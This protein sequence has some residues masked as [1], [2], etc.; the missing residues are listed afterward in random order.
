MPWKTSW[1]KRWRLELVI[2]VS[3]GLLLVGL[4]APFSYDEAFITFRYAANLSRGLGLVYNPGERYLGTTGP[5]WA[6]L[7]GGLHRLVPF[8]SV[9]QWATIL[10][11]LALLVIGIAVYRLMQHWGAG[12]WAAWAAV[13]CMAHPLV[14]MPIGGEVVPVMALV[15]LAWELLLDSDQKVRLDAILL[16]EKH[17]G[18]DTPDRALVGWAW[19]GFLASVA[20]WL[21]PDAFVAFA[22]MATTETIRRRS[23][24][25]KMLLIYGLTLLPWLWFSTYYFGTLFPGTL[26]TKTAQCEAGLWSCFLPGLLDWIRMGLF[27]QA[28]RWVAYLSPSLVGWTNPILVLGSTLYIVILSIGLIKVLAQTPLALAVFLW[29]LL[30]SLGYV[31]LR[32]PFYPWY[33]TPLGIAFGLGLGLAAWGLASYGSWRRW[34]SLFLVTLAVAGYSLWHL[35]HRLDDVPDPR[36]AIQHRLAVWFQSVVPPGRSLM[37]EEIGFLGYELLDYK[38]YDVWGLVTPGLAQTIRSRDLAAGVWRYQ[39][40]YFIA[41]PAD[42]APEGSFR[43]IPLQPWFQRTYRPVTRFDHT[44][45]PYAP[46]IVIYER[47]SQ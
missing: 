6:I 39:P 18:K 34:V 15:L 5:G 30:H 44:G 10:S 21:R 24:P 29:P 37:G 42:G 31:L 4:Y 8:L 47:V 16:S 7:L 2:V 26:A 23:I 33:A 38:V 22:V 45:L 40:D 14:I 1:W 41:Y 32:A 25:V 27:N 19:A 11:G 12:S 46:Y 43:A 28:A 36:Q 13:A 20:T 9:P 3:T 35:Q 17:S